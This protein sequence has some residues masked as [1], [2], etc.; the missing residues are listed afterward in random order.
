MYRSYLYPE[1][2]QWLDLDYITLVDVISEK[3][4]THACNK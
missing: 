4:L 1:S 3:I 2:S